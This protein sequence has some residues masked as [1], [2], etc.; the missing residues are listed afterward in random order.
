MLLLDEG[1]NTKKS[2][3]GGFDTSTSLAT[4]SSITNEV[5]DRI[6]ENVA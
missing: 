2:D 1:S 6:F 5:F 3:I 4:A